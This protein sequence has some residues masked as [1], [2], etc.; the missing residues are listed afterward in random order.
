MHSHP[1]A[2]AMRRTLER[3]LKVEREHL[4][5]I[6]RRHA[7]GRVDPEEILQIAL[8][9]AL[10][11]GHQLRNPARAAAWLSRI[12][13]NVLVDEL[14]KRREPVALVSE[15]EMAP[16]DDDATIDCWC[17]VA[18]AEQ[19]KPEYALILRRVVLDGVSVTELATEL[20]ITP[21]N[22]MVRMHRAREA[23]RTRLREHCGTTSA[24]SCS[25]CGCEER[26]CCAR[27]DPLTR[28]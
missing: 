15:L 20:G 3:V 17:V 14:R 1:D 10:T 26:G 13:R 8:E 21:N 5:I 25:D 24:R 19:L 6:V 11:R 9:R 12:V 16:I 18:Q 23:L 28:Q 22:A 4:L 2:S 7:G 27:P